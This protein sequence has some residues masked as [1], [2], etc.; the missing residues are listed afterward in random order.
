[1]EQALLAEVQGQE[2][3]WV[4]VVAGEEWVVTVRVQGPEVI[5]YALIVNYPYSMQ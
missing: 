4:E 5:A 3:V 1:M 2:E